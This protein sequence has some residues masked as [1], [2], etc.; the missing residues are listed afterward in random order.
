MYLILYIVT[1][2]LSCPM[3]YKIKK[4]IGPNNSG[5]MICSIYNPQNINIESKSKFN[6]KIFNEYEMKLKD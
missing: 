2:E 1:P 4:E 3:S 5:T 6:E